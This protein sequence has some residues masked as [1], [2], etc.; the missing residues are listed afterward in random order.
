MK[1]LVIQAP[2]HLWHGEYRLT[3]NH[4]LILDLAGCN[5][6]GDFI[7]DRIIMPLPQPQGMWMVKNISDQ[8]QIILIDV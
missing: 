1:E 4:E 5:E 2:K 3:T 8:G 7:S 6:N